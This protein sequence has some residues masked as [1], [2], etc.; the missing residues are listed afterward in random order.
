M[1]RSAVYVAR[2]RSRVIATLALST[3]KPWAIDKSCFSPAARVLY[4][5]S[6]AIDPKLQRQGIGRLCM[7]E[8]ARVARGWPADV[9]RLDAYD[10]AAGAG[11][12]YARCGYQEVGRVKYRRTPLVYYE[13]AL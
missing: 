4:L 10:S 1:K 9:V 11:G 5:T 12:F 3:S 2:Q 7:A 13:L 8:A 6:M